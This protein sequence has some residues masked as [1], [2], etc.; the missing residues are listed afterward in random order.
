MIGF[1]RGRI[2]LCANGFQ[3]VRVGSSKACLSVKPPVRRDR[4]ERQFD[5]QGVFA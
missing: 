1:T 4:R 2:T 5:I 3:D